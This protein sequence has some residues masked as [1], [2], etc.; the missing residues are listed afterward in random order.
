MQQLSSFA[1][2]V[3]RPLRLVLDS[4]LSFVTRLLHTGSCMLVQG[5]SMLIVPFVQ[6]APLL[7]VRCCIV[8]GAL[9][10]LQLARPN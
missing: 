1:F 10:A 6:L 9:L 7:C 5:G 2:H 3:A 4:A 8:A